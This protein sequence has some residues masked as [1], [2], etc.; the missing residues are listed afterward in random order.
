MK[1]RTDNERR[2]QG[3][4]KRDRSEM[5][6]DAIAAL[7]ELDATRLEALEDRVTELVCRAAVERSLLR[8]LLERQAETREIASRHRLLGA[9]C[10]QRRS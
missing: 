2:E 5:L 3:E 4:S 9:R 6:E 8:S 7:T 10:W 1:P